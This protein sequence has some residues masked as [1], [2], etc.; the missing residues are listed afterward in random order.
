MVPAT[1]ITGGSLVGRLSGALESGLSLNREQIYNPSVLLERIAADVGGVLLAC[2]PLAF[3]IMLVAVASPLMIGGF[4]FSTKAFTP[5]FMKLNPISGLG[6]MF[7]TNALVELLK[8]IAKTLLVGAVLRYLAVAHFGRGRGNYVESE[9]PAFW[10]TE[11]EQ[12]L[13]A[14]GGDLPALW[15]T[16]RAA[17]S[18]EAAIEPVNAVVTRVLDAT[19]ARLY[20]G[21]K[22]AQPTPGPNPGP[23]SISGTGTAR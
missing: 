5:N 10:Q 2:L 3:A 12:A 8:A 11:V 19:L 17:P 16:V 18:L 7:S 23:E 13:A 14:Q 15:R 21:F 4:N 9:A 1:W 22:L 6:N 20:P